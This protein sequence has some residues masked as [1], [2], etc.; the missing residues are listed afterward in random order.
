MVL[1]VDKEELAGIE[2]HLR[3]GMKIIMCWE[4]YKKGSE[5]VVLSW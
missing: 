4:R 2:Q 5:G 1:V 3:T